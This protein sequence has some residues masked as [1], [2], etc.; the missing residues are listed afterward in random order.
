V[1]TKKPKPATST[2]ELWERRCAEREA[3]QLRYFAARVE[4]QQAEDAAREA[5]RLLAV[6]ARSAWAAGSAEAGRWLVWWWN[7]GLS[8]PR[9]AG[10][11]VERPGDVPG[12]APAQNPH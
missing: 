3:A 12:D 5:E 11:C 10:P 7:N 6:A 1:R 4:L 9:G 8:S 2:R